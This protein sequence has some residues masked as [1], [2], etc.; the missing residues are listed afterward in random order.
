MFIAHCNL[1]DDI[2]QGLHFPRLKQLGLECVHVSERSLHGSH[3]LIAGCP[4]LEFL[5]V[6]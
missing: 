4:V 3:G 6:Q 2:A 5:L 1:T